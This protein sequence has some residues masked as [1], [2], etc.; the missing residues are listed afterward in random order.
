MEQYFTNNPTSKSDINNFTWRINNYN[1]SF[2]TDNG[3]FSKNKID[4]GSLV[5][6]ETYIENI[7]SKKERMLDLGCGYGPIGIIIAKHFTKVSVDML[8]INE[9]AI[10]LAKKNIEKN[11][12]KNAKA[13]VSDGFLRAKGKYDAILFN[14]PIRAGKQVIYEMLYESIDYL[15]ESGEIFIV[16]Q[17]KQGAE[18]AKNELTKIYGNCE[19]LHTEKGYIIFRSIKI[20]K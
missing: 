20:T 5:L 2:N 1:F 17:K 14:P 13:F 6:I 8:D 11:K 18:S 10:E 3:V 12:T 19:K 4:F 16:I 7:K 15:N 9:R